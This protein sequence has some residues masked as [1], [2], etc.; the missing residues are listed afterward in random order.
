MTSYT[1]KLRNNS[2]AK[3][4]HVNDDINTRCPGKIDRNYDYEEH[5]SY[6]KI[7]TR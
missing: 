2:I 3:G 5:E 7:A 6:I 1:E 4:L